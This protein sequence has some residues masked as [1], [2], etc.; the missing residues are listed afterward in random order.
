[1]VEVGLESVYFLPFFAAFTSVKNKSY[2]IFWTRLILDGLRKPAKK[3]I[4]ITLREMC[5][6]FFSEGQ[7]NSFWKPKYIFFYL[8]LKIDSPDLHDQVV[9]LNSALRWSL[10]SISRGWPIP[11][12]QLSMAHLLKA[13]NG[14]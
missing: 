3:I 11:S 12:Q 1:M 13:K 10:P 6:I 9:M 5:I 4:F 2:Y 8:L 7:A 14:E